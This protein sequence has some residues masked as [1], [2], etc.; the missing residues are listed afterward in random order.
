MPDVSNLPGVARLHARPS[1]VSPVSGYCGAFI[2][3]SCSTLLSLEDWRLADDSRNCVLSSSPLP[4]RSTSRTGK[5]ASSEEAP[6]CNTRDVA[7]LGEL[8]AGKEVLESGV[9]LDL[10]GPLLALRPEETVLPRQAPRRASRCVAPPS[11]RGPG[12]VVRG[13]RRRRKLLTLAQ[14]APLPPIGSLA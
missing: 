5:G 3:P 14:E 11:G 9:D 6:L 2:A 12:P 4:L 13:F 8:P 1:P 7:T 10:L